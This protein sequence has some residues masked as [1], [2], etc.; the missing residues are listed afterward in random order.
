MADKPVLVHKVSLYELCL[1]FD[2]LQRTPRPSKRVKAARS[3]LE[4]HICHAVEG[5][6]KIGMV[7]VQEG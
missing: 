6:Q 5:L 3:I 2:V 4:D 1:A 7:Q